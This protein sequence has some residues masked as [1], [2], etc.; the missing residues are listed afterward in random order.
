MRWTARVEASDLDLEDVLCLARQRCTTTLPCL[1]CVAEATI[2]VLLE[3][4][5]GPGW[6]EILQGQPVEEDFPA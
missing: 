3:R 6:S 5:L 4:D 2:D 1:E